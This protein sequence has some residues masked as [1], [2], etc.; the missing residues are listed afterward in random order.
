MTKQE[1][2]VTKYLLDAIQSKI[3]TGV[4][5]LVTLAQSA[6]ESGWGKHAK[7]NNFFGVKAGS[8]WQG[9]TQLLN[10]YEEI[11]GKQV[12]VQA[13]FRKYKTPEESFV[14]H[15]LLLKK[16]FAKSFLHNDPIDFVR[17]MQ[18]DYKY[19]YATDSK[20]VE[21]IGTMIRQ[22]KTIVLNLEKINI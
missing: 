16:R 15:G 4:P 7:G 11:E 21:K 18:N 2:F 3:R 17:S 22:I 12:K 14:D 20:Y 8:S 13:K 10:T 1:E 19:K 6:L 9:E 5:V